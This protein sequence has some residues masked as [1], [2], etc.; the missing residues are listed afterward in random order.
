MRFSFP[1][2]GDSAIGTAELRN[3]L[4]ESDSSPRHLFLVQILTD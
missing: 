2:F 1:S 3:S 4:A